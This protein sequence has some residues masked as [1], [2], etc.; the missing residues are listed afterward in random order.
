[1]EWFIGGQIEGLDE[2]MPGVYEG[3][4]PLT[5]TLGG[6][7]EVVDVPVRY[8]LFRYVPSCPT[9]GGSP[10]ISIYAPADTETEV[11]ITVMPLGGVA[12]FKPYC[13]SCRASAGSFVIRG[14]RPGQNINASVP[15]VK[16]G[17]GSQTANWT[18]HL[19]HYNK[20]GEWE[21]V[22]T[23]R[24]FSFTQDDI[25]WDRSGTALLLLGGEMTIPASWGECTYTGTMT[26]TMSCM[27]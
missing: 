6:E 27:P 21:T 7:S 1:M 19:G 17:K 9:L 5:L 18:H 3:M 8:E 26:I 22:A 23:R 12:T 16:I 24:T 25:Y 4:I 14:R 10:N 15:Q 13:P 20:D 2:E 11:D